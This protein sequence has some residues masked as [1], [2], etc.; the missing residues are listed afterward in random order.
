MPEIVK[1]RPESMKVF[2][3]SRDCWTKVRIILEIL[4]LRSTFNYYTIFDEAVFFLNSS[5]AFYLRLL[6]GNTKAMYIAKIYVY[7]I[8]II[9]KFIGVNTGE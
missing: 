6:R 9:R 5:E 3:C 1:H 4:S 7:Y 8:E 2:I